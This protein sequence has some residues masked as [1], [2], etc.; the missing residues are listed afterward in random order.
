M[1]ELSSGHARV[2][3]KYFVQKDRSEREE[4]R[5]CADKLGQFLGRANDKV[6]AG[7]RREET[8]DYRVAYRNFLYT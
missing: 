2:G 6:P 3:R 8:Y 7:G 4:A 1:T 5:E